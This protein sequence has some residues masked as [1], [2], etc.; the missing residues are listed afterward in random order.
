MTLEEAP[1]WMAFGIIFL[2]AL[3]FFVKAGRL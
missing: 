1:R 2:M 3:W